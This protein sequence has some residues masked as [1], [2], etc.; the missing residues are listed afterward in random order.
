MLRLSDLT[1]P[2]WDEYFP[3]AQRLK[4]DYLSKEE[5]YELIINPVDD[6]NLSYTDEVT[7]EVYKLTMGHPQLLQ[8]ICSII[9]TIANETNQKNVTHEMVTNAKEKVF[10]VNDMPMTI[11]WREFCGDAEREVIE[12]IL[13]N[14]EIVKETK[15]EK[16]AVARLIDYEFITKDC[17][18]YVPLFEK[19]L[20]ERRDLIE[21]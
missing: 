19:W 1:A 18:I 10:E 11:F 16:R 20:K 17:K 7:D 6:F 14:K 2:N 12:Q 21:V 3:Q 13:A 8:T 9:V 4:V 5:S 15:E